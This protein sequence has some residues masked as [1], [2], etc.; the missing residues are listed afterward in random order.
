[1]MHREGDFT[2]LVKH[3]TTTTTVK[4]HSMIVN[5]NQTGLNDT[6]CFS[7]FATNASTCTCNS[8]F[9]VTYFTN[10]NLDKSMAQ[11]NVKDVLFWQ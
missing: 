8:D 3:I 9:C 10:T 1:M 5:N 2:S 11:S 6:A 4:V 7:P